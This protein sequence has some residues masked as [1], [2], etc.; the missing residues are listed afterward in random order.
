MDG[1]YFTITVLYLLGIIFISHFLQAANGW[2]LY[3]W[4]LKKSFTW[5]RESLVPC[6]QIL[7]F[8][9]SQDFLPDTLSRLSSFVPLN[10]SSLC[11]PPCISKRRGWAL[12]RL[13]VL[14]LVSQTVPQNRT[15]QHFKVFMD[16]FCCKIKTY[17]DVQADR[18]W[19][20]QRHCN[21]LRLHSFRVSSLYLWEGAIRFC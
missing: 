11:F 13:Q 15:Q 7:L 3:Y 21:S 2:I 8:L 14:G 4:S 9:Q 12:M 20:H 10:D 16:V 19:I 5:R 17:N 1:K 18:R 6:T